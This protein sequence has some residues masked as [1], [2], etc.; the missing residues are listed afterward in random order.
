MFNIGGVIV[1]QKVFIYLV[2]W[3]QFL[4]LNV[5]GHFWGDSLTFHHHH[6]PRS[7][8]SLIISFKSTGPTSTEM[9]TTTTC[10][11]WPPEDLSSVVARKV[12]RDRVGP[13][14]VV[15]KLDH[16]TQNRDVS[17]NM[18]K[19]A[20]REFMQWHGNMW[21]EHDSKMCKMNPRQI[22][23]L[24]ETITSLPLSHF[25]VDD[26]PK[27]GY[28]FVPWR[29]THGVEHVYDLSLHHWNSLWNL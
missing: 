1:H 17:Q 8:V 5:S 23:T 9:N 6:F 15:V 21:K 4:N 29:V 25:W 22:L 19:L 16:N 13:N 20:P 10:W 27:E 14:D 7:T 2:K 11:S 26:F 18:F 12:R 24:P 28:G 3:A